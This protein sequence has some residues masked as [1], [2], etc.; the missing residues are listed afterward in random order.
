[1]NITDLKVI[2]TSDKFILKHFIELSSPA[3]IKGF[4]KHWPGSKWN[5]ESLK[6]IIGDKPIKALVDLPTTGG[7]LDGGY[8]FYERRMRFDDFVHLAHDEQ[9]RPCYLGYV[10]SDAFFDEI[11]KHFPFTD[12]SDGYPGGS[13]TRL[14]IGSRGT[15]SGLHSDLK[16]NLFLQVHGY[17]T[18]YLI[19]FE[20]T[21]HV[22]P[23]LD[24]IV[25]SRIDCENFHPEGFPKFKKARVYKYQLCPGDIMF[26]P[27]GWWHYLKSK[28]PSISVNHW[29]GQP[30]PGSEY[31]KMLVR[32]GPKYLARTA[33]DMIAYSLLKR[34]YKRD[35]FF[36]PQST[37]ERM[38]NYL[39]SGDFSKEN[40]PVK[41]KTTVKGT[42]HE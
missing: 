14:W 11:Y 31:C 1:M 6:K 39:L 10:R 20:D 8:E 27:K 25:N 30:I 33:R 40:N 12:I 23:Y 24:N 18:V 35:F 42:R 2:K 4:A 16:D 17:K 21:P 7:H 28:T 41:S 19:P 13:D 38:F 34:K 5:F 37:G 3:I 26:I 32:L 36:T 22:Y 9:A 29:F 15:C